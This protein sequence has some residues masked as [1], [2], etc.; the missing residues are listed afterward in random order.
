MTTNS[1]KGETADG[2]RMSAH[3]LC[4]AH[5]RYPP[6][7]MEEAAKGRMMYKKEQSRDGGRASHHKRRD[8]PHKDGTTGASQY[9]AGLSG[10]GPA[11]N[12]RSQNA[13]T[14]ATSSTSTGMKMPERPAP[15]RP[16][17]SVS[18]TREPHGARAAKAARR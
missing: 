17:P 15:P 8:D 1:D 12:G 7:G 6:K 4:R 11:P 13:S 18:Q 10:P 3:R 14:R 9:G 16:N 2:R 5:S